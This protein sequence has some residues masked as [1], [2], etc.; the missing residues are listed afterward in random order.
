MGDWVF[1]CS[2]APPDRAVLP[3]SLALSLGF[4]ISVSDCFSLAHR[5]GIG[6]VGEI[7]RIK[8]GL[9][10]LRDYIQASSEHRQA[11]AAK[12]A[13]DEAAD[14]HKR[15]MKHQRSQRGEID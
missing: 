6:E 13:S 14:F 9:H 1:V 3:I 15:L 7:R 2:L 11:L 4:C 5:I 10:K 8:V 12:A